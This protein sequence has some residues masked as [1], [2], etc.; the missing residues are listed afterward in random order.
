MVEMR[1]VA[2]G[3]AFGVEIVEPA[4]R[5]DELYLNVVDPAQ[6]DIGVELAFAPLR[7]DL[8][9]DCEDDEIVDPM[10]LLECGYRL[11][12]IARDLG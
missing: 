5:F 8:G 10:M 1:Y 9:V 2:V 3:K 4:F 6:R 11:L 7:L 12:E